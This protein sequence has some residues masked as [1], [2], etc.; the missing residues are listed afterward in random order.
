MVAAMNRTRIA[1]LVTLLA[2]GA[3]TAV[4]LGSRPDEEAQPAAE[5]AAPEEVRTQVVRR[6]RTVTR[7]AP[8]D[9]KS[10]V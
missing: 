1:T 7:D 4:A 2:L 10:V 5:T 8:P 9:R 6:S 3:L